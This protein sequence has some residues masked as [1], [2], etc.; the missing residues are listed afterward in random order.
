MRVKHI[1]ALPWALHSLLKIPALIPVKPK[2]L[3]LS[4]PLQN[5]AVRVSRCLPHGWIRSGIKG[6]NRRSSQAPDAWILLGHLQ[7]QIL[8]GCSLR[9]PGKLASVCGLGAH[10]RRVFARQGDL[11]GVS[12]PAR[13]CRQLPHLLF[14]NFALSRCSC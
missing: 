3:P 1:P 11:T 6:G 13:L 14:M 8:L 12:T 4:R 2:G 5:A 9:D 10:L 7:S